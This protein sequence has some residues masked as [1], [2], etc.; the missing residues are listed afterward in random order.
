MVK[1]LS[2][3]QYL[4]FE[5]EEEAI[6]RKARMDAAATKMDSANAAAKSAAI[7]AANS[8]NDSA[9]CYV[10]ILSAFLVLVF[11]LAKCMGD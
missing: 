4:D 7:N 10:S 1:D 6:E 9:G 5:T 8:G 2:E 3:K 11:I